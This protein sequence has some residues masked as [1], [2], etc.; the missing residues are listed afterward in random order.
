MGKNEMA[1]RLPPT[2]NENSILIICEGAEEYD[3][4]DRLRSLGM[5]SRNF[6]IELKDAKSIDNISAVYAY[7]YRADNYKLVVI[8]C[9]TERYPYEQFL[10]MKNKINKIHGDKVADEVV[11]FVNPC[12]LQVVLSHFQPVR[13]TS[14]SKT[15]NAAI[16]E[17]L[18]GVKGYDASMRQRVAIYRKITVENY[19]VMR[20]HL[21][22]MSDIYTDIRSSNV[23]RLFQAL[24][25]G[26]PKWIVDIN[27]KIE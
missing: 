6:S 4:M 13:L 11:Y 8:F 19:E 10:A 9:D 20:R 25:S 24:D 26:D 16:V 7:S 21:A 5:W 17:K 15:D 14:N 3:Y 2:R 1:K 23:L 27:K 18:T 12:T 22:Q